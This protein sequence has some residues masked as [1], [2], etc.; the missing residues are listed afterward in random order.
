VSGTEISRPQLAQALA[1]RVGVEA[2]LLV[3]GPPGAGKTSLLL[4]VGRLLERD[5]W[6]VAYLDLMTAASC[7]D[8]LVRASLEAL[9]VEDF[10]DRLENAVELQRLASAGR[11]SGARAVNALLGLWA[12]LQETRGRPVALLFDE[13]TEIRSL[14]YFSGLRQVEQGLAR[15]L[16]RRP[17]GTLLATSYPT[18]ATKA[19]PAF[20]SF[21]VPR[22]TPTEL[23][24]VANG[25]GW[26]AHALA[27]A[28]DGWPRYARVLVDAVRQGEPLSVAWAREMGRGGRLDGICR[29]T[30][31]TLLLRSRGYGMSKAVL[32][33]VAR[34]EGLNLTGLVK[35][36]GRTPGAVGD[37]LSWLLGVDALRKEHKRYFYVDRVLAAWVRLH[38]RGRLPTDEEVAEAASAV[39]GGAERAPVTTEAPPRTPEPPE[40]RP[41]RR[42]R[43][44]TLMEI[45]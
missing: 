21:V 4:E 10:G 5:G 22:L 30:W 13:A 9:P 20:E 6:R 3:S 38:G 17:R 40:P 45:D 7:P 39:C 25:S 2:P 33:A 41:A 43:P 14:A 11:A 24:A 8:R 44:D 19:W 36:L 42:R 16:S 23:E 29:R 12:G 18:Q 37:Y 31:E 32:D 28:S 27:A 34:E 1:T 26:S 15:A 35:R